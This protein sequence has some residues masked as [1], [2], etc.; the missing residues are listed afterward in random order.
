MNTTSSPDA[1]VIT[2]ATT[3]FIAGTEASPN[4]VVRVF[5]ESQGGQRV[6][7]SPATVE[8]GQWSLVPD[9]AILTI[10]AGDTVYARAYEVLSDGS[11]GLTSSRSDPATIDFNA[12][13]I[14]VYSGEYFAGSEATPGS[15]VMLY[16]ETNHAAVTSTP[17]HVQNGQWNYA[18]TKSQA[19]IAKGHTV[20]AQA[21]IISGDGEAMES[22]HSKTVTIVS[23]IAVPIPPAIGQLSGTLLSGTTLPNTYVEVILPGALARET[24]FG[25][26]FSADGSWSIDLGMEIKLSGTILYGTAYYQEDNKSDSYAWQPFQNPR[27][28]APVISEVGS[29]QVTGTAST[30]GQKV[31]GWR[32]S[33]GLKIVDY[34]LPGS[35]VDFAVPYLNGNTLAEGDTLNLITTSPTEPGMTPYAS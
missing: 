21:Q 34:D 16:D 23:N 28:A 25:P 32:T 8:N 6:T 22:T 12:P 33:D 19:P 9:L 1:P 3:S 10:L 15:S 27:P 14:T 30:P 29:N 11:P 26:V 24:K 4:T 17:A 13:V 5:D 20:Y 7:S 35:A 31:L 18:L 2:T